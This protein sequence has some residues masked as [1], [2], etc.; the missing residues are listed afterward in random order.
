MSAHLMG[1]LRVSSEVG[2]ILP[3]YREAENIDK[4]VAE[5]EIFP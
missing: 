3:T 2:V 5:I 1:D 4:L